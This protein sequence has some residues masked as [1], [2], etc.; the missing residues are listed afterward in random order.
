MP[1]RS[2]SCADTY[3]RAAFRYPLKRSDL[4]DLAEPGGLPSTIPRLDS[5][6]GVSN[7]LRSALRRFAPAD[8]RPLASPHQPGPRVRCR[9]AFT[10]A[11]RLIFVGPIRPRSPGSVATVNSKK[12]E[13]CG[14]RM[15]ASMDFWASFPSAV[16]FRATLR[17][18]FV[19]SGPRF[20]DDGRIVPALGFASFRFVGHDQ[21]ASLAARTA[22]DHQPPRSR[23]SL[24][25]RRT[26]WDSSR[27]PRSR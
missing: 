15:L 9:R 10:S 12:G 17:A 24:R 21:C 3:L 18:L 16:R 8:G 25:V 11:A 19:A 23:R 14:S 4:R 26:A 5:A 27:T 6:H 13:T 20:G 1:V 22:R 2:G 7:L